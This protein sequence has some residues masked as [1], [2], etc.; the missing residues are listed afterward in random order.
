MAVEVFALRRRE[1]REMRD[2][3]IERLLSN[4]NGGVSRGFSHDNYGLVASVRI[5][6]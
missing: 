3:K 1:N 4:L 5:Q 2:G 6:Q